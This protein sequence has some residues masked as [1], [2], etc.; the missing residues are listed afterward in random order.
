MSSQTIETNSLT[1]NG[2]ST[3]TDR[4]CFQYQFFSGKKPVSW[5][6]RDWDGKLHSGVAATLD[7]AKLKAEEYGY[8]DA[9]KEYGDA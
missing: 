2:I 9:Y 3:T 8:R 4:D 6:Y 7:E 1:R 5:D